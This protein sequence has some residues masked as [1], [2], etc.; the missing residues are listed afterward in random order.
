MIQLFRVFRLIFLE[1]TNLY[2]VGRRNTMSPDK[3]GCPHFSS[4]YH[5]NDKKFYRTFL[6]SVKV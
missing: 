4:I 6:H 1:S 2:A 5:S 3:T